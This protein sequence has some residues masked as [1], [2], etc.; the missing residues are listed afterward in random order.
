M[1]LG[2]PGDLV[3]R[4]DRPDLGIGRLDRN[5]DGLGRKRGGEGRHIDPAVS[6]HGD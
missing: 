4:L 6:I 3:K 5:Q 1:S 2:Q